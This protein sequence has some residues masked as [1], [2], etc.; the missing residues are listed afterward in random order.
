[1]SNKPSAVMSPSPGGLARGGGGNGGG[2]NGGGGR[3][4]KR[5]GE[6]NSSTSSPSAN[7][8]AKMASSASVAIL[9]LLLLWS[10][11]PAAKADTMS[12]K[13]RKTRHYNCPHG[14]FLK[15][16]SSRR[17]LDSFYDWGKKGGVQEGCEKRNGILVFIVG[18]KEE[19]VFS[20]L[21][22]P[23]QKPYSFPPNTT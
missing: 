17:C 6:A 5:R 1:M 8:V 3:G 7:K 14:L 23:I 22:L 11:P 9:V 19:L 20:S 13:T 18:P 15:Y 4:T 16:G 10:T 2:G 21:F 12:G